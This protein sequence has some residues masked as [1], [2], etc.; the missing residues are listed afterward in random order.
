MAVGVEGAADGESPGGAAGAAAL[1]PW[2]LRAAYAR[3]AISWSDPT[4][5]SHNW[6][7]WSGDAAP[8]APPGNRH[9]RT[10]VVRLRSDALSR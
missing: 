8:A 3:P 4:R 9:S 10:Q 2:L 6:G 1:D 5:A 7:A